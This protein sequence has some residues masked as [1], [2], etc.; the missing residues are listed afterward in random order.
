MNTSKKGINS[1][2]NIILLD[3]EKTTDMWLKK[4]LDKLGKGTKFDNLT[5]NE[6][7]FLRFHLAD[8]IFDLKTNEQGEKY[9]EF[10]EEKF[11]NFYTEF[12]ENFKRKSADFLGLLSDEASRLDYENLS[13]IV[14]ELYATFTDTNSTSIST[15]GE[16]ISLRKKFIDTEV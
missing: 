8:K 3:D 13:K 6:Q 14:D 11:Q 2:D 4:I 10:N 7:V 9:L 5:A 15:I 16:T 1:D 12:K